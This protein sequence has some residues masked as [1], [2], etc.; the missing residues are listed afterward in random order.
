[1]KK[2]LYMLTCFLTVAIGLN[3]IAQFSDFYKGFQAGL[4]NSNPEG[5]RKVESLMVALRPLQ[6][7]DKPS[8]LYNEQTGIWISGR[9]QNCMIEVE[10]SRDK[11]IFVVFEVI[12]LFFAFF[13]L[14]ALIILGT[15][16]LKIISAVSRNEIFEWKNIRMLRWVGMS[17]LFLFLTSLVAGLYNYTLAT[18]LI[19]IPHYEIILGNMLDLSYLLFGLVALIIAEIYSIGLKLKEEEELTI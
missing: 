3:L 10:E 8:Q 15:C 4:T 13:C 14:P 12:L 16:F 18:Q 11:L 9:I 17:F 2:K 19:E 1:M 7:A 6:I 5:H